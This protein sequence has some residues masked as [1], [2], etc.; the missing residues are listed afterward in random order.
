MKYI[1]IFLSLL[2]CTAAYLCAEQGAT[3]TAGSGTTTDEHGN[4]CKK[5]RWCGQIIELTEGTTE[6]DDR[7]LLVGA[8]D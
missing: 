6:N 8:G 2:P 1:L 5:T 4:S 3:Q 7:M